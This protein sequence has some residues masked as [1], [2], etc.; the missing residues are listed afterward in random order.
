M[1]SISR[2]KALLGGVA[3]CTVAGLART[4]FANGDDFFGADE[5]PGKP[6]FLYFGTVKSDEGKYLEGVEVTLEIADPPMSLVTYSDILGRFRTLDAGRT[7]TDMGY[8]VNPKQITV[9]VARGGFRQIRRLSRAPANAKIGNAYE[10][11]FVM[12]KD[13][14]MPDPP[15]RLNID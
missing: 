12:T 4:A 15:A 5:I 10:M 8:E 9:S 2:R 3:L 7:L 6:I 14:T 1:K 13:E 11:N